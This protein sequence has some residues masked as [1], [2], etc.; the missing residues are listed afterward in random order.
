MSNE[1]QALLSALQDGDITLDE[2]A[3]RFRNRT[4]PRRNVQKSADYIALATA[5]QEDPEPYLEESFDDVTAAFHRGEISDYEYEV[6]AQAMTES[7]HR[8]GKSRGLADGT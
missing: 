6:L 8:E 1:I 3:D 2:V 4:W 7:M 5:A